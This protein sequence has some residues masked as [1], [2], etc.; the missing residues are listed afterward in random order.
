MA[1][2]LFGEIALTLKFVFARKKT[3][4][5]SSMDFLTM[6]NVETTAV[7][8]TAFSIRRSIDILDSQTLKAPLLQQAD[9]NS[10]ANTKAQ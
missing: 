1:Y 9:N 3:P 5:A 8:V 10:M 2:G 6:A 7:M 4:S